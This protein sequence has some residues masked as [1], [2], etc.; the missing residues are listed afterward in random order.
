M[1]MVEFL[2]V[3]KINLDLDVL[4]AFVILILISSNTIL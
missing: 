1:C 2:F 3:L 4:P